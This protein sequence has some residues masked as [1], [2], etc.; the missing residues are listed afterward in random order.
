M[1]IDIVVKLSPEKIFCIN[2]GNSKYNCD[3]CYKDF[4]TKQALH[5][6]AKRSNN[7][8]PIEIFSVCYKPFKTKSELTQS[9][10]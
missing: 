2:I 10:T 1:D 8:Q 3:E 6:H 4:M 5:H 7:N 9:S